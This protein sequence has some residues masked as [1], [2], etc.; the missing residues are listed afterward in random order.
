MAFDTI[1][2]SDF[3]SKYR[4]AQDVDKKHPY[5]EQNYG[6]FRLPVAGFS[7][8][9]AI[10]IPQGIELSSRSVTILLPNNT[11][12]IAFLFQ[13]G[14]KQLA[15]RER[16]VLFLGCGEKKEWDD[17]FGSSEEAFLDALRDCINS[18]IHFDVQPYFAYL[19]GYEKGASIALKYLMKKPMSYIGFAAVGTFSFDGSVDIM[20]Y[21]ASPALPYVAAVD[22]PIPAYFFSNTRNND[23]E[24]AVCH[25][26]K[27]NNTSSVG[28]KKEKLTSYFAQQRPCHDTINGDQSADV[29][30]EIDPE[31]KLIGLS[32][33]QKVLNCLS[34][35]I[36]VSGIG[37]GSLHQYRTL[38][39]WGL[40][41]HEM[42]IDGW[43]RH[44]FEYIPKRN[45]SR[46]EKRPLLIFLH[47]SSLTAGSGIYGPEWMNVAESRDFIAA[48]PT[49]SLSSQD[50]GMAEPIT[51]WNTN[52]LDNQMDDEKFILSI[53]DS[54]IERENIDES[55]IYLCGHSLGSVM[56]QRMAMA[57]PERFAAVACNAGVIGGGILAAGS[58]SAPGIRTD[59]KIPI[60]IQIG[61]RDMGGAD[62]SQNSIA[63]KN[64]CYWLERIGSPSLENALVHDL[65]RYKTKVWETDGVPMLVYTETYE[66][67]HTI[68]PQDA[69]FYYDMFL[70]KYSRREDG[71]LMYMNK[72]V[73]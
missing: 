61:E 30:V 15:D 49:G 3:P 37:F 8:R 52:H 42:T 53:I 73:K 41:R 59:I 16:I 9:S 50:P 44:W 60:W 28:M 66:K 47:G 27:R 33:T 1:S 31:A 72:I 46:N 17:N 67:M 21:K 68:M 51:S 19:V 45:V 62:L 63:R 58:Y 11:D 10:Y 18:R 5:V 57:Y 55:R 64:V 13:S 69:W 54:I 43:C 20:A 36:R 35:S 56:A 71:S 40:V 48:F 24:N 12:F 39:D 65:G 23:L 7:D 26:K 38:K 2:L 29:F 34:R 70:S 25:F 6:L 4:H 32:T 14:W 22:V